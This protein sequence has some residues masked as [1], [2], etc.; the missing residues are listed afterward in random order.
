M[1]QTQPVTEVIRGP[2]ILAQQAGPSGVK[3]SAGQ[4]RAAQQPLGKGKAGIRRVKKPKNIHTPVSS[5]CLAVWPSGHVPN[6]K[7]A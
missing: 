3:E 1:F 2:T 4:K 5:V 6:F 7:L